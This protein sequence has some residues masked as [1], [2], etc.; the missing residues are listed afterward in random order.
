MRQKMVGAADEKAKMRLRQPTSNLYDR[1]RLRSRPVENVI[2][3]PV[4]LSERKIRSKVK[5]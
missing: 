5:D 2:I 3:I 1:Q 4:R